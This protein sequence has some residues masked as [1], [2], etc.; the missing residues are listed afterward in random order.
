MGKK[1][2]RIL[3][4]PLLRLYYFTKFCFISESTVVLFYPSSA[5]HTLFVESLEDAFKRC[6]QLLD[7]SPITT[8]S[9]HTWETRMLS[10][11]DNWEGCRHRLFEAVVEQERSPLLDSC[12][13]C[14]S[15]SAIIRCYDCSNMLY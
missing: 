2:V 11:S 6:D 5:V 15:N 9:S 3:P 12:S 10:L 13:T 8:H 7:R 14:H 1:N 4:L